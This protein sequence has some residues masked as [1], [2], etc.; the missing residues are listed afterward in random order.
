MQYNVITEAEQNEL[1]DKQEVID[2]L[3][4][5]TASCSAICTV[6]DDLYG[7]GHHWSVQSS[8]A[9]IEDKDNTL[10]WTGKAL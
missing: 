6:L 2:F 7:Y 4:A 5:R 1:K 3:R 9:L 10:I 8:I